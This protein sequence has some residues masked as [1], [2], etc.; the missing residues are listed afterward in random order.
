MNR[1]EN[2]VRANQE[3][4]VQALQKLDLTEDI[5]TVFKCMVCHGVTE[6]PVVVGTCCRQILGCKACF[7]RWAEENIT[8][9]HCR[10]ETG[11][12]VELVCFNSI[13]SKV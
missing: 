3:E 12:T 11:D 6:P 2:F 8:C 7:D 4:V 10:S 9:P 1:I 5:K 13:L